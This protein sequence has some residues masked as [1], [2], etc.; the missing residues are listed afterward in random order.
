MRLLL[1]GLLS[2]L[3]ALGLAEAFLPQLSQDHRAS[4]PDAPA[5][6]TMVH[7]TLE[8]LT[9]CGFRN[10]E[11]GCYLAQPWRPI[12]RVVFDALGYK[13]EGLQPSSL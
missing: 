9:R 5:K 11:V 1:I 13:E 10:A 2:G 12:D 8:P 4:K 7:E 3:M 6:I